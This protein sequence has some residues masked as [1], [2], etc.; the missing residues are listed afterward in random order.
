M[1]GFPSQDIIGRK[2]RL[3]AVLMAIGAGIVV[4]GY[5]LVLLHFSDAPECK[6]YILSRTIPAARGAI[7]DANGVTCPMAVSIPVWEYHVDPQSVNA[8]R[9]H[10]PESVSSN[11][12]AALN[13]P[14]KEVLGKF[15]GRT[16]SRYIP[17]AESSDDAAHAVLADTKQVS[18][19][20]IEERQVRRYPH[21][22]QMAHVVGFVNALAAGCC[23]VELSQ[24]HVLTGIPGFIEGVRDARNHEIYDLRKVSTEP[25]PGADVYLTLDHNIQFAVET[26]L[27]DQVAR[28]S[29]QAGWAIV[30]RVR[31]G[32][33]IAMASCP[34]FDP[35]HYNVAGDD[36]HT[37]ED[38]WRNRAISFNYEPGSMMK[39]LTVAAAMNERLVNPDTVFDAYMGTWEYAGRII[40]DHPTGRLTV[41]DALVKSSNIVTA[42]IGLMLGPQR[43]YNY[44]R[45]F[46]LGSPVGI[47]LPGEEGGILRN[48]RKWDNV[49]ASRV[50]FGQGVTV[51]AVQM[52]N[53]Y[54]MLAN[55]GVLLKPYVIDRIEDCHG[56]V[57]YRHRRE[58]IGRPLRPE[59]ARSMRSML[60]GVTRPGGTARRAQV[61]GY[62]VAGKTGTAQKT[63]KGHVS[64]TDYFASFCGMI[65][66]AKPEYVV[67]VTLDAPEFKGPHTGGNAAAPVF[68]L[69]ADEL[70]RYYEVQP[71]APHELEEKKP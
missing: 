50:P 59:V 52:C 60:Y 46:G 71:D 24:N 3:W 56:E 18:G 13:L 57:V 17:L 55:D 43:L 39:S 7:Y 34:D 31:D 70:M 29:A 67:L 33:I 5:R 58:V 15:S 45:A 68:Q 10:T 47:D 38:C 42:K 28:L 22:R 48:W 49:T 9:H 41:R 23:G 62:T 2:W 36:S 20:V 40:H 1:I 35:M 12:A 63:I 25:V 32:A 61:K 37:A 69:I 51:T 27:S 54:V 14:Y 19:L 21:G 66:A 44:L 11:V 53:A 30:E 16:K 4:V 26:A 8:L 64:S 65:P 6:G